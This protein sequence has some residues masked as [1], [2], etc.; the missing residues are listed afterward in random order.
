MDEERNTSR[1]EIARLKA[2]HSKAIEELSQSN[3]KKEKDRKDLEMQLKLKDSQITQLGEDIEEGQRLI[4][5][6][7]AELQAETER[8]QK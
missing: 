1:E 7:K 4:E 8:C 2:E 6:K 5:E 3:Q